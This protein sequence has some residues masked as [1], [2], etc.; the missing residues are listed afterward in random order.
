VAGATLP[1]VSCG[2][3]KN[4]ARHILPTVTPDALSVSVSLKKAAE[5]L[6]LNVDGSAHAGR[7]TDTEGRFWAFH[8]AGL[9]ADTTY[10]LS[11][12]EGDTMIEPDWPLKTFPDPDSLPTRFRLMTY[13][14]AGGADGFSF[15]NKQFFKPHAFRQKLFD[16][17]LAE[18][19]DAVIANG[20]H[21]YYDLKGQDSPPIGKGLIGVFAG[22]YLRQKYGAF[23]RT[24]PILGNVNEKT[25]KTIC[26]EQIADLYG[27]RFKSVPV[28]FV[29]DD[30]DYFENDDADEHIVTFPPDDFSVRANKAI[31]DLYYPALPEAPSVEVN[32]KFGILRYGKLFE[33]PMFDCAGLLTVSGDEGSLVPREVEDWIVDRIH[34]SEAANFALVP[35]HPMG[36]TAGKWREWYPDVVAP[37]GVTGNVANENLTALKGVLTAKAKKYMWPMGW[38]E[39]HQ[40]L[41][42]ALSKR[43]GIRFMF[44]GD[45][46]AQG[47]IEIHASGDLALDENPVTSIIVGPVSS[48]DATWPSSS[49]SIAAATPEWLKVRD[50]VDTKEINGF[51]IMDVTSSG[52]TIRLHNCGG[53]D[54]SLNENGRTQRVEE[55]NI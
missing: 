46:H 30:H 14:C 39:Q 17:G 7:Q 35:S 20:D 27:T 24:R 11:L 48:S 44:S 29:P 5:A 16:Q 49:R 34:S 55:F 26:D 40:R 53:Y 22:W 32:R 45:I 54:R 41:L 8:V 3:R 6:T 4:T 31:T 47:A 43:P 18:Q 2:S 50:I 21:I 28:F 1:L 13:T 52:T 36:W 51:A 12:V 9:T 38:W 19:P 37:E 25:L 23:D 33:A 15:G 42:E 10:T